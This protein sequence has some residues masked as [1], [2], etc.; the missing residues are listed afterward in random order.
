[1]TPD[2]FD[3]F[4]CT[5]PQATRD[6]LKLINKCLKQDSRTCLLILKAMIEDDQ[7]HI[8]K[9]VVSSGKNTRFPDRVLTKEEREA[10]DQNMFCLEKLVRPHVNNYLVLLAGQKCITSHHKDWVIN[11]MK[12][13][14]DVYQLFEIMKRRSFKHLSIF[15]RLLIENGHTMIADVLEKGGVAEIA[16][17][18]R[19]IKNPSDRE[20]IQRR[21]VEQ[22]CGYVDN[23]TENILN[24]EQKM[25]VDKLVAH[26]YE[27]QI[28]F[29]RCYKFPNSIALIFQCGTDESQDWLIDY[30]KNDGLKTLYQTL[31]PEL[32]RF[33]NFGIDVSLTN[34]SKI[35]SMD[36]K[37]LYQSGINHIV[38]VTR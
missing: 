18:L 9:F 20:N 30:C 25:F 5:K 34:S 27:N 4:D 35:H 10:I 17:C 38:T 13:N 28:K 2:E 19:K 14:K 3:V 8:A 6:I 24:E 31:Q 29:V 16:S 26:L 36:T 33:P 21:I 12:E 1:M 37:S 11:W 23:E 15:N 32:N 7:T 22:L